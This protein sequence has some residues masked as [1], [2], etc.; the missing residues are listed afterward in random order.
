[1]EPNTLTFE[2]GILLGLVRAYF[3]DEKRSVTWEAAWWLNPYLL[4]VKDSGGDF[5]LCGL[6]SQVN[7]PKGRGNSY[8]C[9]T[10]YPAWSLDLSTVGEQANASLEVA[11][12]YAKTTVTTAGK[13]LEWLENPEPVSPRLLAT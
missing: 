3:V 12:T 5:T 6:R 7:L 10:R 9:F 11:F 8:G 4:L 1:M 13:P 2:S